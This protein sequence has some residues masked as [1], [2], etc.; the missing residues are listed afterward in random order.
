MEGITFGLLESESERL[1]HEKA[2]Y[3]S[4]RAKNDDGWVA[5]H[6]VELDGDNPEIEPW[7]Y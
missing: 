4:Y 3:K 6:Y 7:S 1:A 5:N 2:L